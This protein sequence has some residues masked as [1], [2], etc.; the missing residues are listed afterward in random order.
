MKKGN[1][2]LFGRT[3]LFD[4]KIPGCI[5]SIPHCIL[6]S[7]WT[8]S[9]IV[10][11]AISSCASSNKYS[12]SDPIYSNCN[13]LHRNS[14]LSAGYFILRARLRYY[15]ITRF[16]V[17]I[18]ERSRCFNNGF[19]VK[20]FEEKRKLYNKVLQLSWIQIPINVQWNIEFE[21]NEKTYF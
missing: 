10:L 19:T 3:V 7:Y 21:V 5:T 12:I 13:A 16:A 9:L 14:F 20:W 1:K 6:S 2:L 8:C 15:S 18:I 4:S 11:Y 17:D